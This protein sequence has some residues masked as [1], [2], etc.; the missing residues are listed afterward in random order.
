MTAVLCAVSLYALAAEAPAASAPNAA[1]AGAICDVLKSETLTPEAVASAPAAA[2]RQL[3]ERTGKDAQAAALYGICLKDGFGVSRSLPEARKFFLQ[4]AGKGNALGQFWGGWLLIRGE[5]GPADPVKG[6]DLL[7][8]AAVQGLSDAML[9]LSRIYL[10]GYVVNGKVIVRED[11]ALALR[12]LRRAAA[13]GNKQAALTLGDW[14]LKGGPV[15]PDIPRAIAWFKEAEGVP[16]AASA[17]AEAEFASGTPAVRE[18]AL[19]RLSN[20]ADQGDPRAR[21]F[22]AC[23]FFKEGNREEAL[24]LIEAPA[25][26]GYPP[27]MTAKARFLRAQGDRNS[28][29]LLAK[30]AAAGDP[31]AMAEDGFTLA[32]TAR[33]AESGK[34]L[35]LLERAARRGVLEGQVKLGRVYLQGRLVPRDEE[36]AFDMFRTA[37][38]KGSVEAK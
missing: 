29:A 23:K 12:Y 34:G 5:G 16:G 20:L 1:L 11:H 24:K 31:E 8:S 38:S 7:E 17:L 3:K 35:D 15:Q 4:A 26:A 28:Q 9:L 6:V 30:A 36:K 13:G 32:T 37:S 2:V 22:M 18:A 27:A 33:G 19:S 14:Y 10:E 25:A 21:T